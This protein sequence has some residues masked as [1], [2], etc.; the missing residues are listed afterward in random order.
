M[1]ENLAC[2]AYNGSLIYKNIYYKL[3]PKKFQYRKQSFHLIILI[4]I[5]LMCLIY[6]IA[7][8]VWSWFLPNL[9]NFLCFRN[10]FT[11]SFSKACHTKAMAQSL[12]GIE[13]GWP[14][15]THISRLS[16]ENAIIYINFSLQDNWLSFSHWVWMLVY[17]RMKTSF[18]FKRLSL[19]WF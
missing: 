8:A 5:I 19:W 3:S 17:S 18:N 6:L 2:I 12:T 1:I 13:H 14:W 16:T 15:F 4:I 9:I 11:A 10:W 7:L